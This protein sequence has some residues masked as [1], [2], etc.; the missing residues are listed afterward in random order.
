MAHGFAAINGQIALLCEACFNAEEQTNGAII[1]KY[2]NA[3]N[4]RICARLAARSPS[5]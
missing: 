5:R 4:L 1:R 3:P 2:W